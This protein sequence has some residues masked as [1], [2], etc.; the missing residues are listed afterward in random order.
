MALKKYNPTTPGRRGA[1]V[2]S[3]VLSRV[4]PKRSLTS[5]LKSSGGRNNQGKITVRHRGA[6]VKRKLRTIDFV[7]N[8]FDVPGKVVTIEYDPNRSAFIALVEYGSS[9]F[10]YVIAPKGLSVGDTIYSS[11][12]AIE[13]KP[14]N[15]MPLEYI[16]AGFPI[17]NIE[18]EAGRGGT[19]VRSAGGSAQVLTIEGTYAHVKM[20]SGEV[21]MFPKSARATVGEVSNPDYRLARKGKAGTMRRLGVRPRVRGKAM[22]PVD[23]PHG[24]GEGRNPIGLQRPMTPWGKP[25][26]GVKTRNP[27][28][29]TGKLILKKRNE[30]G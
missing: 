13:A 27:N 26:L 4:K 14:G 22:N 29:W 21:R 2:V 12:S 10:R 17:H 28:K 25:A 7:Q 23:H 24:G 20:P 18:L 19:L 11:T 9:G 16:P 15:R 30:R 8:I 3:D 5:I 6:G 1:S